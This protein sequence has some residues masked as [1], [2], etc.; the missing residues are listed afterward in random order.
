M[1]DGDRNP[2]WE[3]REEKRPKMGFFVREP[4]ASYIVAG[5]KI[6]EVRRYPTEIR[7]RVGVVSSRGWIGTVVIREVLGPFSA[8]ELASAWEKHRADPEFLRNYARGKPLYVWVLSDPE[9]FPAPIPVRKS[10][11]PT[12]WLRLD[13]E[14]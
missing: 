12:V 5:E 8:E 3:M 1:G 10:R 14:S 4:Y 2:F 11:G 13:E 7:G 6:W 9:M